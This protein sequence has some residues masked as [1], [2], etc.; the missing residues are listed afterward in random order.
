VN[1][2]V[3]IAHPNI[4]L[5]KYWGKRARPG[6]FPAVPSLSVTLGG[7][8]TTTRVTFDGALETDE[9][10]LGGT[11]AGAD[12]RARVLA[13]VERVRHAA[14]SQSRVH[15]ESSS[16]FPAGSGLASSASGFA[17]LAVAAVHA[18]GLDWNDERVSAARS[19][20]GGFVELPAGEERGS[21]DDILGARPVATRDP[22]DVRVLVCVV[23]SERKKATSRDGMLRT[24]ERSPYYAA[25]LE[26]APKLHARMMVAVEARDARRLFEL[27]EQSSL[28]MHASAMG[29]GVVYMNDT[30]HALMARV[31]ELRDAGA[32]AFSTSDAGPHVKVLTDARDA[33]RVR[34]A[35]EA[36]PGVL[37]VIVCPP[38][39]GAKL[40]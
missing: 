16:D 15:V 39:E 31:R 9:V 37:R 34:E 26:L 27:A 36:A 22:L 19:L 6:N 8:T 33:T 23:T 14:G 40:R 12:D 5:S 29:A 30:T 18:A 20:F 28:A 10:I 2:A 7:M 35:L 38:G 17:A 24:M 3:A 4:A 25:W 32:C 11:P 13:V 21:E 1:E